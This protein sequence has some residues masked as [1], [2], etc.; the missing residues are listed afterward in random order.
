M[1][2]DFVGRLRRLRLT[3]SKPARLEQGGYLLQLGSE[4][5]LD[6]SIMNPAIGGSEVGYGR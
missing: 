5:D 1:V 2:T 6:G 3:G 4:Q